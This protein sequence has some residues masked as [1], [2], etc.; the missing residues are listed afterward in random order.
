MSLISDNQIACGCEDGFIQIWDLNSLS[1]VKKFKAHDNW[2]PYLLCVEKTKLISFSREKK[3]KIWNLETFDCINVFEGH[4]EVI[5]YLDLTSV[6]NLLSCSDDKTVKL[7]QIEIGEMLQSFEFEDSVNCVKYLN[8]ELI[9]AALDNREIQIYNY[10][11]ME[12]VKK[13]SAH[14]TYVYRFCLLSNG[15]LISGSKDGEMKLWKICD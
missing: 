13:I 4:S 9:A 6:G 14:S 1:K 2:I 7:W 15:D 5:R 12:T 11:K 10:I 8:Y 3:I